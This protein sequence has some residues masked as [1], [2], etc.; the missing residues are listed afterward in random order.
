VLPSLLIARVRGMSTPIPKKAVTVRA[1]QRHDGDIFD[2]F[3]ARPAR[4]LARS[5]VLRFVLWVARLRKTSLLIVEIL[6]TARISG[7][8]GHV[9]VCGL[10]LLSM[11]VTRRRSLRRRGLGD[12]LGG[13]QGGGR[14]AGTHY[15][16]ASLLHHMLLPQRFAHLSGRSG[17]TLLES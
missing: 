13:L 7:I 8:F 2:G 5:P 1:M 10:C 4:P 16:P 3:P 14:R 12:G 17:F 15:I 9:T 6:I 11:M